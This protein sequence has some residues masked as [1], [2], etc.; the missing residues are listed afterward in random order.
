MPLRKNKREREK[1]K[2]ER[3][4]KNDDV[5]E[6]RS[7]NS[8]LLLPFRLVAIANSLIL[9]IPMSYFLFSI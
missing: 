4:K 7:S 3:R 5:D 8:Q 2:R 6:K 9:I 1:K